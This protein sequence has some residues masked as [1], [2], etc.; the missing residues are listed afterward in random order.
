[1]QK[2]METQNGT[3]DLLVGNQNNHYLSFRKKV[4]LLGL[5][6]AMWTERGDDFI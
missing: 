5:L 3:S 1:M 2:N 4:S 6:L